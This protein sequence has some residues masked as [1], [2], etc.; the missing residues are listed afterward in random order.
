[1]S[2]TIISTIPNQP[3]SGF[4]STNAQNLKINVANPFKIISSGM[5]SKTI[6]PD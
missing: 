5:S 4:K 3:F 2:N 6:V 1:M